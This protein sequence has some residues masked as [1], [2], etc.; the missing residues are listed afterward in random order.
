MTYSVSP[1]PEL[2]KRPYTGVLPAALQ[3]ELPIPCVRCG[4]SLAGLKTSG[5]CPECAL[6]ISNSVFADRLEYASESYLQ[7]LARGC[8]LAQIAPL[9]V[10]LCFLTV[11]LSTFLV[12][13]LTAGNPPNWL[14][15]I[16]FAT[17]AAVPALSMSAWLVGWW[18]LTPP[19]HAVDV[20]GPENTARRWVRVCCVIEAI[21]LFL[22]SGLFLFINITAL[23]PAVYIPM[24]TIAGILLPLATL[25]HLFFAERYL[26]PLARRALIKGFDHKL[27]AHRLAWL[28]LLAPIVM[29]ILGEI[30]SAGPILSFFLALL[31]IPIAI[32][33]F[34]AHVILL[35]PIRK[36][37]KEAIG[38]S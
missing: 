18:L 10:L 17:L 35:E 24:V 9:A 4:Y 33:L 6:P 12:A 37:A 14:A 32:W 16:F 21:A 38:E 3:V 1:D 36:A 11:W 34:I 8:R 23:P 25:V 20:Q 13:M 31:A 26:R 2:D 22:L 7:S 19:T 15:S 5:K 30:V 27:S 28:L 29:S